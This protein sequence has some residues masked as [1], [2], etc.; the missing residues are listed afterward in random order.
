MNEQPEDDHVMSFTLIEEDGT[1]RP[2]QGDE[3][4]NFWNM[5]QET[6]NYL[7]Q[8]DGRGA[9]DAAR[10][11]LNKTVP[12]LHL[13]HLG[14]YTPIQGEGTYE[15]EECYFRARHQHAAF[16]VGT[17]DKDPADWVRNL[18]VKV[19]GL[20]RLVPYPLDIEH[21]DMARW[22][23]KFVRHVPGLRQTA[24]VSGWHAKRKAEAQVVPDSDP[25][26]AGYLT[27]A[28]CVIIIRELLIPNLRVRSQRENRKEI[29]DI[30]D[31]INRLKE[32]YKN[33]SLQGTSNDLS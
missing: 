7:T 14:G 30:N 25:H 2:I 27:P 21:R 1:E 32:K 5:V 4:R 8:R 11:E 6:C 31:L 28:E 10:D 9:W 19:P 16:S 18:A 13:T 12:N 24:P 22:L 33:A 3:A 26:G 20:Y 23:E 29:R 15:G 17:Y